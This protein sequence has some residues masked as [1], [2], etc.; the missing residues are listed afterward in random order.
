MA[1]QFLWGKML[2]IIHCEIESL[3]LILFQFYFPY[4]YFSSIMRGKKKRATTSAQSKPDITSCI[5]CPGYYKKCLSVLSPTPR[6]AV[7]PVPPCCPRASSAFQQA[8]HSNSSALA[9][10][11]TQTELTAQSTTD[12]AT[13]FFH[14]PE[15]QGG[16]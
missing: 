10:L 8:A 1:A 16:E 12:L 9:F 15:K 4:I 3:L 11:Q 2:Q 13:V 6:E 14:L 7:R 5:R